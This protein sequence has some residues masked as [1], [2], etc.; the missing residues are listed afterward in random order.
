MFI[1]L[2]D[3]SK[4]KGPSLLPVIVR[5]LCYNVAQSNRGKKEKKNKQTWVNKCLAFGKKR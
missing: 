1:K 3:T 4:H 2:G 5:F